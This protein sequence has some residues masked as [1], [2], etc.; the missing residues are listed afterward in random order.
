MDILDG[1]M[2]AIGL[3]WGLRQWYTR[4]KSP[5][6]TLKEKIDAEMQRQKDER[7]V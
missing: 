2:I 5:Q 7:R 4:K 3:G 1:L 6:R